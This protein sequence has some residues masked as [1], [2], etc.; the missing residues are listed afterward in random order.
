MCNKR[1]LV[2]PGALLV[3]LTACADDGL[4]NC[5]EVSGTYYPTFELL[6]AIDPAAP[7]ACNEPPFMSLDLTEDNLTFNTGT[8]TLNTRVDRFGCQVRVTYTQTVV[9]PGDPDDRT[10]SV[11]RNNGDTKYQV[12]GGGV[13]VGETVYARNDRDG[14]EMCRALFSATWLPEEAALRQNA[15]RQ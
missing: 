6:A 5:D 10:N 4:K 2:G 13:L 7:G 12:E 11:V 15:Q 1:T 14:N 3:L 8:S 9:N